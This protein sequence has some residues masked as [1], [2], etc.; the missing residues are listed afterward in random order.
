MR[1]FWW[2]SFKNSEKGA[3]LRKLGAYEMFTLRRVQMMH[4]NGDAHY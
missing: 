2:D 1:V 4:T 3:R